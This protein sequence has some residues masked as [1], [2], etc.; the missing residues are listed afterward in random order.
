MALNTA[1]CNHLTPLR[2]KGL[3]TTEATIHLWRTRRPAVDRPVSAFLTIFR[4]VWTLTFDPLTSK[5]NRQ[6]HQNCKFAEI[7]PSSVQNTMLVRKLSKCT[8]GRWDTS[9]NLT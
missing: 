7:P 3:T 9:K 6:V 4:M 5:S 2:F 1:K 8:R